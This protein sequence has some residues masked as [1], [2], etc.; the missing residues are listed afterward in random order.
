MLDGALPRG[1]GER[2]LAL[3]SF[4]LLATLPAADLALVARLS[5]EREF[6][7]GQTLATEG[8]S[9][10]VVQL[11]IS[12]RAAVSR[13]GMPVE[14]VGAFDTLGLLPIAAELPHLVTAVAI[15]PI[16]ALELDA[17][18]VDD[19][20]EDDFALFVRVLRLAAT[21]AS[22][23]GPGV[24]GRDR[25]DK[26][27]LADALPDEL[28]GALGAA[29]RLLV[30]RDTPLFRTAPVDGLA[31]FAKR[32]ELVR[33]SAGEQIEMGGATGQLC[34]MVAGRAAIAGID[35]PR[36]STSG[37]SAAAGDVVGAL[38]ALTVNAP[39]L[40]VRARTEVHLLR[41]AASDLLDVIEDHHAMG[42][43][44]MAEILRVR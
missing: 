38:E 32:L 37:A 33:I 44:L 6:H 2:L 3:R 8:E 17:D 43:R 10:Q 42:R 14:T 28:S 12:G 5:R 20:L 13:A 25:R 11:L 4:S 36:T 1:L 29:R 21:S 27:P 30:L 41:G 19:V 23:H 40:L 9:V 7:A 39:P 31:A 16:Q 34:V 18:L 15:E 35:P 22:A 26:S 24:L